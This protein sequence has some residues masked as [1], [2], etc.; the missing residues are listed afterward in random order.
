[1]QPVSAFVI[2]VMIWWSVI[3]CV[4]PIGISTTYEE[5]EEGDDYIAPGAPKN[6]NIKKKLFLTTVISSVLWV[7]ACMV[8]ETGAIDFLDITEI[9]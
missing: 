2:F 1:M 8:I 7:I 6:L 3:F 9:Q 5:T 4:L